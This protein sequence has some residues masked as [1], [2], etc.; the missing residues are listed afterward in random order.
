MDNDK[1]LQPGDR[2]DADHYLL[3]DT[4]WVARASNADDHADVEV[5]P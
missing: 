5:N 3:A 2:L 1:S 4:P